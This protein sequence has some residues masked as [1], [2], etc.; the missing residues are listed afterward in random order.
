M[1]SRHEIVT[2]LDQTLDI[3]FWERVDASRNGL[4]VIGGEEGTLVLGSTDASLELFQIAAERGAFLVIVHHGLFWSDIQRVDTV[5]KH[6]WRRSSGGI[7]IFM[8]LTCPW[9][10][11]PLLGTMRNSCN[12]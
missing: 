6:A 8:L 10:S 9:T 7:L 11:I 12:S 5:V 3:A 1:V 2:F 4:Q